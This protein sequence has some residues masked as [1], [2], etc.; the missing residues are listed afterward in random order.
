MCA[1]KIMAIDELERK[2]IELIAGDLISKSIENGFSKVALKLEKLIDSVTFSVT[3][4]VKS[5]ETEVH[6]TGHQSDH[7]SKDIET[8]T[9][10]I[11]SL[12]TSVDSNTKSLAV[13]TTKLE[14]QEKHRS[15]CLT[16]WATW[17]T[18]AAV[19]IG[20]LTFF[21]DIEPF[22]RNERDLKKPVPTEKAE[23]H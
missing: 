14:E 21:K 20:A 8:L 1:Q 13:I 23:T 18:V 16:K 7:N 2:E 19:L 17:A 4:K 3:H 11:A 6:K 5:L 10:L 15:T 9:K 12:S 22:L